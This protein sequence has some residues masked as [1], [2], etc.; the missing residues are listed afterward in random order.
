[1]NA[2]ET[3]YQDVKNIMTNSMEEFFH[4]KAQKVMINHDNVFV[5]L[6]DPKEGIVCTPI[7][8]I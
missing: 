1:M 8:H 7:E 6:A 5:G 2:K 3:S 4:K